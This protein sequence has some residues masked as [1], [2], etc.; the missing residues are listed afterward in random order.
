MVF[1][2]GN[3]CLTACK[4]GVG[5]RT[6]RCCSAALRV[7]GAASLPLLHMALPLPLFGVVFVRRS[8]VIGSD[9]FT[10]TDAT[11]WVLDVAALLPG[12]DYTAVADVAV[13]LTAAA[14]L[15]LDFGLSLHVQA[16]TSGWEYRGCVSTV[17]PSEVFPTAWPREAAGNFA[18]GARV[19]ITV[20]PLAEL[21]GREATA[22][23]SRAEF[24][25][26]RRETLRGAHFFL[27]GID[28]TRLC[29]AACCCGPLPFRGGV[30]T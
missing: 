23:A 8:F 10:Q 19:G 24:A 9:A 5:K 13:F 28:S 17:T 16:G 29:S 14:A 18:P 1:E 20:E 7:T 12:G 22:V 25:K 6:P 4:L 26:V 27:A 11:H 15:P 30:Y 21:A 2:R 3:E